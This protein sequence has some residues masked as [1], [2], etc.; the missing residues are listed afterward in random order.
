MRILLFPLLL[1]SGCGLL[2]DPLFMGITAGAIPIF[3]RTP[4]DMAA[5]AITGKDCSVVNLDKGE[6]YCRDPEPPP[7]PPVFCT[8]SLGTADC[9]AEPRHLPNRPREIADGPRTL[10]PEQEANRTR[11][12]PGL[13]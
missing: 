8:R 5:S 3:H 12:W 6:R 9:W 2:A 4:F 13:W 11:R 10:T 7:E 1:L